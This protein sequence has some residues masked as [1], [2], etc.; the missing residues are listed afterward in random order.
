MQSGKEVHRRG[1]DMESRL[2]GLKEHPPDASGGYGNGDGNGDGKDD[3][4]GISLLFQ[5]IIVLNF[6][7]FVYGGA[8]FIPTFVTEVFV[9]MAIM[10]LMCD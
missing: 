5:A 1:G 4:E 10:V 7:G 2:R 6:F 3:D 9:F 8:G